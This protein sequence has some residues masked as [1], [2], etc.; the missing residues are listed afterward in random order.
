MA[1]ALGSRKA[2]ATAP[3]ALP[4]P[5]A[6]RRKRRREAARTLAFLSPW[7]IGFG[8]FFAYPLL[9]TVYFSFMKYDGFRPPVFTGLRNWTYVFTDYPFFWEGLRNTLWL[10]VVMVTL[11]V[12]FGL[13]IGLLVT[14]IRSGLGFFRTAFYLPYL[15][16]PVAATIAFAFLLNPGTGPVDHYLG[17]LGLPQPGWFNDPNW[18]KPALTMLAVWGIGDLMVIFMAALLDVPTEQYEAAELDGAGPWQRFRYVTFP[19]IS[20]I[21]MFAV[22]TGVIQTMQYYT[23]A[24][25]AGQVASGIIGGS[26]EQFEPGYPNGSTWTLP[27]MVYNLGFQRFDT[28][29]ACVVALILF[30]ISMAFT[31]LLLRRKSGFMSVED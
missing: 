5:P 11:R 10:V 8:V 22:V 12:V 9:S 27:Q 16:P 20:P 25:V 17:K 30:A 26:G 2:A 23:Q 6:L 29:S 13:G 1:L 28:G 24:I 18:S 15:A 3:T 4:V 14:K 31:S 19:N 21:V 7:L